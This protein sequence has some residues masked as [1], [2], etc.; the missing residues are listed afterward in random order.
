MVSSPWLTVA[1]LVVVVVVL[2]ERK[3]KKTPAAIMIKMNGIIS[4]RSRRRAQRA[5]PDRSPAPENGIETRIMT[6]IKN[7]P[8]AL[9]IR[10]G[11]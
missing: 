7:L 9:S 6:S 11:A 1:V 2:R 10:C 4:Q 3:P 5:A 8:H